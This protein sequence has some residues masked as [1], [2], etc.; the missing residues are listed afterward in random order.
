MKKRFLVEVAVRLVGRPEGHEEL[1]S[2]MEEFHGSAEEF[3]TYVVTATSPLKAAA[4]MLKQWGD[5]KMEMLTR[6]YGVYCRCEIESIEAITEVNRLSS[7]QDYSV[8]RY[9]WGQG[10]KLRRKLRRVERR[11][12]RL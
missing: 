2:L 1:I 11:W 4:Q 5:G 12:S 3:R 7:D 8:L 10:P 9:A 6:A